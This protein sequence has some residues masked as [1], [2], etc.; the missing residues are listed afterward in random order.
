M[1]H[2]S[3]IISTEESLLG[4]PISRSALFAKEILKLEI[5]WFK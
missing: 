5:T 1:Y 2:I 3:E 4:R